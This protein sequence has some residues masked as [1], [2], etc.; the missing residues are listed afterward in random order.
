MGIV[1][2]FLERMT[3]PNFQRFLDK[4]ASTIAEEVNVKEVTMLDDS[5]Q[6]TITYIPL[7]QML[8]A[9]FGKDTARIIAAAKAWNA[10]LQENKQLLVTDGWDSW[11]LESS[12]YEIRYSGLEEDHQTIEDGVIVSLDLSITDALKKEWVA[13]ELSRFLNQMRKDAKF[14]IDAKV[15]CYRK[16]D[17]LYMQNVVEQFADM[18]MQEA[19][20]RSIES[21]AI[22]VPD[23]HALFESEE[24]TVQI[25]LFL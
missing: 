24:W 11:T 9:S 25:Q 1:F 17:D 6:V 12:M 16:S 21:W 2:V 18:L 3:Q 10:I 5:V 14:Q 23:A 19:L 7:G 20:L 15:A 8:W 13:R 22:D 4:Y